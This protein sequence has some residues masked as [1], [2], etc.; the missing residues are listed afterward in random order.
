MI[1]V[2]SLLRTALQHLLVSLV[3]ERLLKDVLILGLEKVSKSTDNHVDDDILLVV[4]RAMY[5]DFQ[6]KSMLRSVA[7][8]KKTRKKT[9]KPKNARKS[10]Q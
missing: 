10:L 5:P 7:A 6:A 3:T 2:F 8:K 4:K 9:K 1:F